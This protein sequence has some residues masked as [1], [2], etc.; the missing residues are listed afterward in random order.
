MTDPAVLA[1]DAEDA[2]A[3]LAAATAVLAAGA[4]WRPVE[5]GRL[6]SLSAVAYRFLRSRDTLR[7]VSVR[8]VAGT[9]YKEGTTPVATVFNLA[10]T[11]S[12]SFSLTGLDAKGAATDLPAGFSA[13]WT[14]ADPD[15]TGAVLTPSADSTTAVLGAGVP[16]SNLMVSVAVTVTNPDGTTT[17]I[18][19]AEAVVVT[20]TA[21]VTVGIVPGT[22]APA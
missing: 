9:P 10:D 6:T 16:D 11:D 4:A 7:A 1:A 20:A 2:R 18:N 19:G 22:P 8:L 15:A 17:V 13:A 21:A 14:L 12:V 3:A 5:V